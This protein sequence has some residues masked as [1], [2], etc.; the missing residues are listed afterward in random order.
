[1]GAEFTPVFLFLIVAIAIGAGMMI[2]SAVLGP[3]QD[4]RGEA[5][6]VRVGHGPDRRR[7]AAV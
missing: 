2:A 5:D 3:E 7:P 4:D 6:A 1:M